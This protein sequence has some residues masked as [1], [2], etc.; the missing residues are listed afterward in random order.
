[1]KNIYIMRHGETLFNVQGRTQG[2]SDSPLTERGI[3]QA[4]TAGEYMG[5]FPLKFDHF[6]SSTQ[7]RASDTL[8]LI[9]PNQPY[10]RLKGLK[11]VNFGQFEGHPQYLEVANVQKQSFFKQFGGETFDEVADRMLSALT[12]ICQQADTQNIF[13]VSHG[14]AMFSVLIR[15]FG[16][17][18]ENFGGIRNLEMLHFTYDEKNKKIEFKEKISTL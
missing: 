1:M 18:P 10:Q 8:E 15:L 16:H 14:A 5:S 17:R 2:W 4:K 3:A 13:C 12:E 7:E 11:E 6:Y 9:F